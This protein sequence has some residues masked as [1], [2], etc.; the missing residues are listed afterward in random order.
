MEPITITAVAAFLGACLYKAG[1]KISEKTIETVFEN[2]KELAD[3]GK[4]IK[5]LLKIK[6]FC[7]LTII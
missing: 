4:R 5:I 1:E 7:V 6:A 2:K 3:Q